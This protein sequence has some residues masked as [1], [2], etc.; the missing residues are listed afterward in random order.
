M[1]NLL[2]CPPQ[3]SGSGPPDT[4]EQFSITVDTDAPVNIFDLAGANPAPGR[5]IKVV[6][7][8]G[9][10]V[11][12]GMITHTSTAFGAGTQLWLVVD[13]GSVI[14]NTGGTGGG[15]SAP[16]A[17]MDGQEGGP[18]I[19]VRDDMTITNNGTIAGAGGGGGAGA[20]YSQTA[21]AGSVAQGN[22][23]G[24]GGG[25][26]RGGRYS[27]QSG[28]TAGLG[29]GGLWPLWF[30]LSGDGAGNAG[31]DSGDN[32]PGGG[33]S[34]GDNGAFGTYAPQ[35]G[36]GGDWGQP[37][38]AG[39]YTPGQIYVGATNGNGGPA[40]PALRMDA[41]TITWNPRGDI[42]GSAPA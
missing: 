32:G 1:S 40:A 30:G 3:G 5:K 4:W 42:R 25:G 31:S 20:C 27:R 24:G 7:T 35:G 16:P 10:W 41:G 37:G 21:G 19:I 14:T 38:Q 2:L 9:A 11:N 39:S 33:G 8:N 23:G 6:V 34:G 28:S 18:A 17:D 15:G 36:S 13:P 22:S 29:K 12:V 26:G